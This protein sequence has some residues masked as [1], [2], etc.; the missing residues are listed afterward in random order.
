[1]CVHVHTLTCALVHAIARVLRWEDNP[2]KSVLSFYQV[3]PRVKLKSS[4]LVGGKC[5]FQLSLRICPHLSFLI[6]G[7]KPKSITTGRLSSTELSSH[8]PACPPQPVC[9]GVIPPNSVCRNSLAPGARSKLIYWLH[10]VKAERLQVQHCWATTQTHCFEAI[11]TTPSHPTEARARTDQ[12]V[13]NVSYLV[14]Q[15]TKA[16]LHEAGLAPL[17]QWDSQKP[18]RAQT[19]VKWNPRFNVKLKNVYLFV[20]LLIFIFCLY[21]RMYIWQ[22]LSSNSM[23]NSLLFAH[24]STPPHIHIQWNT[25]LHIRFHKELWLQWN[26][27]VTNSPLLNKELA[28]CLSNWTCPPPPPP[29]LSTEHFRKALEVL[30]RDLQVQPDEVTLFW[31]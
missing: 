27:A 7:Q 14:T 13:D 20:H 30:G 16:F 12:Y 1:M 28:S 25:S 2:C 29:S 19:W 24:L 6:T 18:L 22:P 11:W 21:K 23:P 4:G 5:R 3:T 9:T 8:A 15:A 10:A 17:L 31:V 26:S